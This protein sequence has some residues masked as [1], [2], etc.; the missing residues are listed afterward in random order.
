[1]TEGEYVPLGDLLGRVLA[2]PV[3]SR[4]DLPAFDNSAV[5]GYALAEG[6]L[7]PCKSAIIGEVAAGQAAEFSVSEGNCGRV[8]TG[9]PLPDGTAAVVMQEDTERAGDC[10]RIPGCTPVGAHIRRRGEELSIGSTVLPSDIRLNPASIAAIAASGNVGALAFRRPRLGILVTGDELVEPGSELGPGQIFESNGT[11][12]RAAIIG[13]GL[14]EPVVMWARDSKAEIEGSLRQLLDT[15]DVVLTSGGVS[16]GEHDLVRPILGELGVE[17]K[18]W[19]VAMKPSRPTY[20]G[21]RDSKAVFG[22]P[23]NPVSALTAFSL[24]VKPYLS[25][26]QGMPFELAEKKARLK[27]SLS[28]TPDREEFVPGEISG[29]DVIPEVTRASHKAGVFARADCL[30][31][32][33][34]ETTSVE[35]GEEV[36]VV[37]LK[38]Q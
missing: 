36:R 1:M 13:M 27:G 35:S 25:A 7:S 28:K 24:F 8:F 3:T 29:T 33:P 4:C 32:L 21:K 6:D 16:V 31:R 37:E 30:I 22:L 34:R 20:F 38:W 23:G 10:L 11:A 15:C 18:F 17:Q 26:C 9:A 14:P 2:T 5:D 19:R 12:L